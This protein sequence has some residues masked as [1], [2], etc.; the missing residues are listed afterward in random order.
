[1]SDTMPPDT[2]RQN[3]TLDDEEAIKLEMARM[4]SS[5]PDVGHT[6]IKNLLDTHLQAEREA[7]DDHLKAERE[8]RA[9]FHTEIKS[10]FEGLRDSI[11]KLANSINTAVN[12]ALEANQRSIN[13]EDEIERIVRRLSALEEWRESLREDGK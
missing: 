9:L 11:D 3:P 12:T 7:R 2:E 4:H 1:V 13:N 8:E 5:P 10:L 6:I